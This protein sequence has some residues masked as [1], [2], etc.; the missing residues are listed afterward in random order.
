MASLVIALAIFLGALGDY[1][2]ESLM[3]MAALVCFD[4][5]VPLGPDF[6]QKGGWTPWKICRPRISK[7]TKPSMGSVI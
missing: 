5:L 7:T 4:G 2:G 6:I 3:R 1:S